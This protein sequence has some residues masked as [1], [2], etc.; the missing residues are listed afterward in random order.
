[1]NEKVDSLLAFFDWIY[2]Q[3]HPG[4]YEFMDNLLGF[5]NSLLVAGA[6]VY[7]AGQYSLSKKEKSDRERP[8]VYLD[9]EIEHN[10]CT[11]VLRNTGGSPAKVINIKF[12]PDILIHDSNIN[13]LPLFNGLPFLA[14]NKEIKLFIGSLIGENNVKKTYQVALNYLD[15]YGKKYKDSQIIDPTKYLGLSRIDRK[16]LHDI[17][18][19]LAELAKSEGKSEHHLELLTRVLKNG[20]NIRNQDLSQFSMKDL[21]N[22]IKNVH[23]YS[24]AESLEY[25][26][27]LYDIHVLLMTTKNK[28]L[29]KSKITQKDQKILVLIEELIDYPFNSGYGTEAQDKWKKLVDLL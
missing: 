27:G 9:L 13:D 18:K 15:I 20:L 11:L 23:T 16:G 8:F 19:S 25:Y 1:M 17:A 7:A 22:L 29:A 10:L 21:F 5:L 12:K 24:K 4:L 6:L 28:I 3:Q 2:L 14:P 26:P